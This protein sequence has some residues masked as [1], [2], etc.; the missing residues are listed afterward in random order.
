MHFDEIILSDFTPQ[1]RDVLKQWWKGER[2]LMPAY[3]QHFLDLEKS[4]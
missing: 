1:N 3:I 2:T 4:Q